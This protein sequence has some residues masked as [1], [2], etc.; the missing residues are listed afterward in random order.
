MISLKK[1]LLIILA[2]ALLPFGNTVT[3]CAQNG[4][5]GNAFSLISTTESAELG[6][7]VRYYKHKKT[8]AEVV[9]NDNQAERR[10]FAIGFRTPPTDS[11]GANHVLEH[12]L[13]C[14]SEK[15]PTKNIMQYIRQDSFGLITNAVTADDCTYYL[16]TATNATEYYNVIDIY[17]NGIFHP[18]LLR[19]ENIF[20][21]QGIRREYTNGKAQYN[22][23]VYNEL[24]IKNLNTEENSVNFLADNLYT[25]I[26]GN[27]PPSFNAGGDLNAIK[28]LTYEDLL[29]VYNTYYIPSNSM[30]YLAGEQDINKTLAALDVFFTETDREKPDVSYTDTKKIPDKAISEYNITADTKTVD[31]GFMSSGVPTAETE[32]RELYARDILFN[33]IK[34]KMDELNSANYVSGGNAGGVANLAL[35]LSEVPIEAKDDVI[36]TYHGFLT[37]LETDGIDETILNTAIE[38]YKEEKQS[39]FY[40]TWENVFTGLLY[41]D[42]PLFYTQ[43]SAVCGYLKEHKEYFTEILKKYFTQNP[44]SKIIISG[45]GTFRAGDSTF[46]ADSEDLE[47]IKRETKAFQ[48]WADTEDSA[49][50]IEKIPF[51]TLDEVKDVPEKSEPVYEVKSGIPF[52]Y[53]KKDDS[54]ASLYFPLDIKDEDFDY[55]QLVHYFLEDRAEKEGLSFYTMLTPLEN[56]KNTQEINP[57]FL[58]GLYGENMAENLKT[59]VAFLQSEATWNTDALAEY[60]KSAPQEILNSYYDPYLLSSELHNSALS[61]GGRFGYLFPQNTFV[62]GSPRYYY[63]LQSLNTDR[64]SEIAERIKALAHDIVLD[65]K[66]TVEYIGKTDEYKEFQNTVAELFANSDQHKSADLQLPI[67]YDSAATITKLADANHFMLTAA[68]DNHAYSGKLAVLGKVLAAKYITPTMRGKY[69]AYGAGIHFYETSMTSVATGLS[70]IDL[71][72]E[73][74]KGTGDYLR[75]IQ[76]TQK[77]LDAFIVSAVKEYDEWDYTA[78][79]YGA[80]FALKGKSS[81]DCDRIRNEMLAATV[82]DIKG[83]ADFIDRLVGQMRIFAV[84]GKSAADNAQFD[85]SY[86]ADADTLAVTPRFRKNPHAYIQGKTEKT[87]APDEYITRAETAALISRLIAD[88]REPEYKNSFTDISAGDWYY[89]DI[90]SIAEKEIMTGYGD[91]V[92]LPGQNITRA[93]F[94]ATLSKFIFH[95]NAEADT[96]YIDMTEDDWFYKPI[97]KMINAGYFY[98]DEDGALRPND[99]ITRSEAVALLNR[100]LNLSYSGTAKSPFED[101]SSNHWAYQDILAA[102]M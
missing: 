66:P 68:Y 82:A 67:G 85:F 42:D 48:E 60:I 63:F 102:V 77:E 21:Q 84:L 10:E 15:Y 41:H 55:M 56:A 27:T 51:L 9:Y 64:I 86:Y 24:R 3:V 18:L 59:I 98:G 80:D 22:G 36:S 17:M 12:S 87:F 97:I 69:G 79:E 90:H 95:G 11:K 14:G 94:A 71:A 81:D 4:Y 31:I 46:P 57:H 20:R 28:E 92:F 61:A 52:Y 34:N 49:D 50:V 6:G 23:V 33:I 38:N 91:G 76:L 30:T 2:A 83:Y 75:N 40:A 88:E 26:Y 19:D 47:N 99:N 78:S 37:Q 45:N 65:S 5:T 8:G 16:L 58:L 93:E 25:E 1:F 44:C 74:W 43:P 62:K 39:S 13:L 32:A 54:T 101:V 73:V 29:R 53:T 89:E 70:D 100:M 7:T 35:L 96:Q 72:I